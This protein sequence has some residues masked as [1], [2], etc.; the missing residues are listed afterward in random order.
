MA[1]LEALHRRLANQG[2]KNYP[3]RCLL[4]LLLPFSLL[5]GM[6]SWLRGKCYDL[7]WFSSYRAAVPVISVGN[8]AVGGTGKTPVVDWL[9]KAF[10]KQGKRPAVISRGYGGSFAGDVGLV[11]AGN[12]VLLSAAEAGDEPFLLA[13]RNPQ[14]LILIAKKRSAGVRSAVAEHAADV[15]ILDD[16][17]QHRA[18]ARDL[19]LLLLDGRR[20]FGN[21]L[22]LPGGILREFSGALKRADLLLLTR[23]E[24]R[25]AGNFSAKPSWTSQHQIADYAVDLTGDQVSFAELQGKKLLA[26]AG[27]A[28]PDSFF[29]ALSAAGL[30][31]AE[32][33]SFGDHAEYDTESLATLVSQAKGCTALLTTEKDAVKLAADMFSMPCYQVPMTIVINREDELL[34]EITQRLWRE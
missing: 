17:F 13:R 8:L 33:L 24:P 18:V 29:N 12:G 15:I 19:D 28:D 25:T 16:G 23:S 30:C 11:S 4:C 34:A 20:P 27:I 10:L 21:G 26:F 6:I 1:R 31:I 22:P 9:L 32:K 14:A 7:G 3:E 5:Y 2:P